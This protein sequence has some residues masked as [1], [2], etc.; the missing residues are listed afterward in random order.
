MNRGKVLA[1]GGI[2]CAGASIL[3]LKV[4]SAYDRLVFRPD[5]HGGWWKAFWTGGI[6]DFEGSLAFATST[7]GIVIY[8]LASILALFSFVFLFLAFRLPE[9][10]GRDAETNDLDS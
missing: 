3:V 7:P 8:G 2:A 10:S 1:V 6:F 9:Q 5:Y 4:G